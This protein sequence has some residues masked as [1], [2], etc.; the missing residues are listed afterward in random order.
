MHR[1]GRG[2]AAFALAA[3]GAALLAACTSGPAQVD[4]TPP[5]SSSAE[6]PTGTEGAAHFDD[7]ALVIGDGDTRVDLFLDPACPHCAY[8]EE[9]AGEGLAELAAS[10]AISYAIHPLTFL[11][12]GSDSAYSSRASSAM[13]CAAVDAPDALTGFIAGVFAAQTQAGLTNDELE[14]IAVDAGADGL[15]PCISD[16]RY[17]A[18]AQAG[19]DIALEGPITV[20]GAE[21]DS[22]E[23]TP[24]LFVNGVV[25]EGDPTDGDAVLEFVESGGR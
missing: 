9:A 14:Q 4:E 8:F 3:G 17:A 10:G 22:I 20:P 11:D 2:V 16:G 12:R 15:G 25:Y 21:I 13:T 23:G 6:L 19:T 18:W 24:T 5:P 7:F 1:I